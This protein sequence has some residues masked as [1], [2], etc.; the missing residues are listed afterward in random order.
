MKRIFK[1]SLSVL[2]AVSMV[3]GTVA[4]GITDVN[5]SEFAI[6]AKAAT[7]GACG[8]NL[9]WDYDS[10]TNT[11]TFHGTGDMFDYESKLETPW[12]SLVIKNIVL[13]EGITHVG[14][15]AFYKMGRYITNIDFPQILV[16][17][18]E[19]AFTDSALTEIVIPDNVK[20][21]GKS[22]FNGCS[23][24][25][26]I[27]L[28][29]SLENIGDYAFGGCKLLSRLEFGENLKFIGENA[30][31]GIES[32]ETVIFHN[33][34]AVIS[35]GA[36]KECEKL[37]KLDLGNN[38][39]EIGESSF[40]ECT[41]LENISIP[42]SVQKI[43]GNPF[44]G[45]AFY[46]KDENWE[47]SKWAKGGLYC[48]NH[49]LD[50]TN[51]NNEYSDVVL[52]DGTLTFCN[53][54]NLGDPG[55]KS[56]VIPEGVRYIPNEAFKSCKSL[57]SIVIPDSV[58]SIG[59]SA[60]SGC[61]NLKSVEISKNSNLETI[62]IAAFKTCIALTEINIPNSVKTIGEEAFYGCLNLKKI[63]IGDGIEKIGTEAFKECSYY[64]NTDNWDD[65]VLYIGSCL[66][67]VKNSSINGTF[68]AKDG[69][70]VI[71]DSAFNYQ[72][73]M[74]ALSFPESLTI[75]GDKALKYYGQASTVDLG[76][77]VKYIGDENIVPASVYN[78]HADNQYFTSDE[79]GVLFNKD[80]TELISCGKIGVFSYTVP[81]SVIK[82]CDKAFC[83]TDVY[84]VYFEES[85]QLEIIGKDAFRNLGKIILPDN[86]KLKVIPEGAF[87]GCDFT[88]I[89]IPNSVQSVE[90]E[91]FSG[92]DKLV[93]ITFGKNL[94]RIGASAF[95][96]C[97]SIESL[98]FN[99]HLATIRDGAFFDC[100]N[101]TKINFPEHSC[102]K[103]IGNYAFGTYGTSNYSLESVTIPN[104]VIGIG[105][106][107][108]SYCKNLTYFNTG[109][110]VT[111]LG[112]DI[113]IGCDS[114]TEV[115]IGKSV[116]SIG[117]GLF[118]N[119]HN[120]KSINVV[121]GN[122]NFVSVDGVLYERNIYSDYIVELVSYPAG[123]EDE[124]YTVIDGVKYIGAGSF[125]E[126]KSIKKVNLPETVTSI[127]SAF[128]NCTSL[129]EIN[130][131]QSLTSIGM[132]AFNTTALR[133]VVLPQGIKTIG[134]R[135]FEN[136]EYLSNVVLNVGLLEIKGLAFGKCPSITEI[137][138][139]NTVTLIGSSAFSN[140][141][142]LK[143][144]SI[145]SNVK[146][147]DSSAFYNCDAL[148]NVF[149][150][151]NVEK[152]G[153]TA[154]SGCDKLKG[155]SVSENNQY[156]SNDYFGVLYN[157]DQTVLCQYPIGNGMTS[158][159]VVD[160]TKEILSDA[161]LEA[162]VLHTITLPSV[163]EKYGANMFN[164]YGGSN[165][166]TY[167]DCNNISTVY[168]M[169]SEEQWAEITNNAE[170]DITV[171]CMEEDSYA[172]RIYKEYDVHFS[173]LENFYDG[174]VDFDIERILDGSAFDVITTQLDVSKNEIYDI[175]MTLDDVKIQPNGSVYVRIPVPDDYDP[176]KT[177]VYYIDSINGSVK[178]M[179]A[180]YSDGYM[181]FYTNHFSNYAL[182]EL[183]EQKYNVT[184]SIDGV[185]MTEKYISGNKIIIPDSPVKEGYIFVGWDP[186]IPDVMPENDITFTAIFEENN[187]SEEPTR[188]PS[189]PATKPIEPTAKPTEPTDKPLQPSTKPT[190]STTKP[191]QTTTKPTESTTKPTEPT[192]KPVVTVPAL[193]VEIRKP[194]QT[195]IK[196]GDSII[197][198]A[199]T[200]NLPEGAK[201]VWTADNANFTYTASADGATCTV[202]PSAS[203]DTTFTAIVYDK[204][205]NEI[206]NDSQTM[207]AKVG[208]FQKLIAFFKKLFGLTKVIPEMFKH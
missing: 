70:K 84:E 154:F 193:A 127:G 77:N 136:C 155:F 171:I 105:K 4:F 122:E 113:F 36:F 157:K 14:S 93:N 89:I 126:C 40:W 196:Y 19:Y 97:V 95:E 178:N 128:K 16:S 129:S 63:S 102:L 57:E 125:N 54:Y 158:Y 151:Q 88:E 142:N 117:D 6:E 130:L 109:N 203:G 197:L 149:I 200:N 153:V 188:N 48:G 187:K 10:E 144:I 20:F 86:G 44:S 30:F 172:T 198:H 66:I 27:T 207:T 18:G 91:A 208:F 147:I 146:T 35:K 94:L 33:S 9:T 47:G 64:I 42:D 116:N 108:F 159:S 11:I 59:E 68:V 103:G 101:I 15:Y 173:Y 201:I 152:I 134:L 133:S 28:G 61:S 3:F 96:D 56:V 131:P 12:S 170:Y 46:W 23:L 83:G 138:I 75:I 29:E 39:Q 85:S 51:F 165:K 99:E 112:Q 202:S 206:G 2:L 71:A 49:L 164:Y 17:I 139:P 32:L 62:G 67:E 110:G 90:E 192:T 73:N 161:F 82:I 106:E 65:N 92:C 137:I 123:K 150:P 76:E 43:V 140:C 180:T 162:R 80:K 176:E 22:A 119:C 111:S 120:L 195:E 31:Y 184:W 190:E 53:F 98:D 58:I 177:F 1:K 74:I 41:A 168:Y 26:D 118:T 7:S 124:E 104:T 69:T 132:D 169:G 121:E 183:N 107:A 21:I 60:F 205:G 199:D 182:V 5:W 163:L 72:P 148:E 175:T 179:N 167:F 52:K 24:M 55:I 8:Y 174:I 78:V 37:V 81:E 135:A 141:I 115:I 50:F 204:D 87:V 143:E 45:T 156:Y 114:L 13:P 194:S 79:Y 191:T 166:N 160:A 34:P 186:E 25:T 185:I 38:I 100:P 145:G 189:E 181:C